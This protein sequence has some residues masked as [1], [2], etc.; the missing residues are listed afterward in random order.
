M[1]G[2]I[3]PWLL[4]H[5]LH[6]TK[7]KENIH[8]DYWFMKAGSDG[9]Q[10]LV[11]VKDDLSGYVLFVLHRMPNY[12]PQKRLWWGF[13]TIFGVAH[14]WILDQSSDFKT[15]LKEEITEILYVRHQFTLPYCPWDNRS[16][17]VVCN[18]I[19]K[20][21]QAIPWGLQIPSEAGMPIILL[22]KS[23]LNNTTTKRLNGRCRQTV[24]S[25]LSQQS[26]LT[27][28][29]SKE[30]GSIAHFVNNSMERA[31]YVSG[32]EKIHQSPEQMHRQSAKCTSARH[33]EAVK[34]Q[35]RRTA[36][37]KITNSNW[38][39]DLRDNIYKIR[40]QDISTL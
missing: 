7:P 1:D 39:L 3:I 23:A 6:D 26:A 8:F 32:L 28:I 4:R 24:F 16:A 29:L 12:Q 37:P 30:Y 22:V 36:V 27:P 9:H 19:P 11:I 17:E 13:F 15:L 34:L 35:N 18:E 21:S 5:A 31:R 25:S 2:E 40:G 20:A 38:E 14:T 10:Y 33:E